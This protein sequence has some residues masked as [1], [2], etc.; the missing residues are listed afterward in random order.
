MQMMIWKKMSHSERLTIRLPEHLKQQLMMVKE[1]YDMTLND[2]V[3]FAVISGIRVF[4]LAGNPAISTPVP[5][6]VQSDSKNRCPL[7]SDS[8]NPLNGAILTATA[9]VEKKQGD[10]K[11]PQKTPNLTA[12]DNLGDQGNNDQFDSKNP[13]KEGNL[14]AASRAP[15]PNIYILNKNNINIYNNKLQSAWDE[16][17]QHRK[18]LRKSIKPTQLKRMWS[19]FNSIIEEFGVDGLVESLNRSVAMG[20]S[21]VFPPI[22]SQQVVTESKGGFSEEDF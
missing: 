20:W 15:F 10:S 16:F 6:P 11:T 22:Q 18:E 8:K 4:D 21:G 9:I 12:T 2:A 13:Q 1:K 19:G 7:Q 5:T 3:K 17:V 14:T